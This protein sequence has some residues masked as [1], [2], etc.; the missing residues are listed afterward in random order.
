M[1]LALE[2]VLLF[3]ALY[4]VVTAALWIAGGLVF[5]TTEERLPDPG[6][7]LPGVTVLVPAF[8]EELVIGKCVEAAL[9]SEYPELELIVL[10]DG[11]S[12]STGDA[13]AEA[14]A[15]DPRARVHRD[16]VNRGKA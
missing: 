14:A 15:G 11:S 13:A 2:V 5:R 7:D 1:P 3:V 9:A 8:N 4:P 10:D 12:D 6:G 16:P